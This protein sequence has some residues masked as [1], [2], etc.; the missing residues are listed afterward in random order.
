MHSFD[1]RR[2]NVHHLQYIFHLAT[3][4]NS[5]LILKHRRYSGVPLFVGVFV[6][7]CVAACMFMSILGFFRVTTRD[8]LALRFSYAPLS[9]DFV[10]ESHGNIP[11]LFISFL[12]VVCVCRIDFCHCSAFDSMV[13]ADRVYVSMISDC[14]CHS[15]WF[16]SFFVRSNFRFICLHVF[17]AIVPLCHEMWDNNI[18]VRTFPASLNCTIA[19]RH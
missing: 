12:L 16:F 14:R 1:M 2:R 5:E 13:S 4:W 15:G 18:F 7:V 8:G 19:F 10:H 9:Y 3:P 11:M 17:G 6:C